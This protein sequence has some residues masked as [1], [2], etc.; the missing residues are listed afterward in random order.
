VD[1]FAQ[2]ESLRERWNVLEHSFYTRWSD[3]SLEREELAFYAGEYRHAVVALS[4]ALGAASER[5]GAP[6][7]VL[8]EHAAEEAAHVELWDDFAR[9]LD[10]DTDRPPRAETETCM[11]SWTAGEDVLEGLAVTYAIESGQPA[12]S[13]TKLR[14]LVERY[15]FDEGPATEYFSLHAELDHQHAAQSR[16]LIEERLA[17]ADLDRL[18]QVVENALK[19]NWELLDGVEREF[20]REVAGARV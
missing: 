13:E 11:R 1:F 8:A 20:G 16:E 12:I 18:L 17:D 9:A 10:A 15:G 7:D 3:G 14:G 19:G 4:T 6:R 2:V 5:P